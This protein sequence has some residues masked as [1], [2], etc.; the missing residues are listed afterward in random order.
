M[1]GHLV[2]IDHENGDVEFAGLRDKCSDMAA[3]VALTK[4]PRHSRLGQR[5]GACL[6]VGSRWFDLLTPTATP[7]SLRSTTR[8][9]ST[10]RE[11]SQARSRCSPFCDSGGFGAPTTP[12]QHDEPPWPLPVAMTLGSDLLVCWASIIWPA[13]MSPV[14]EVNTNSPSGRPRPPWPWHAHLKRQEGHYGR[15]LHRCDDDDL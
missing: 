12:A 11:R 10:S 15:L 6:D 1:A 13:A 14:A 9:S 8:K 5:S 3:S 4:R 2:A 7:T